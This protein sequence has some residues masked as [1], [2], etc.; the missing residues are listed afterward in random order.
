[1]NLLSEFCPDS[2]FGGKASGL[3]M[4]LRANDE[5]VMVP[6]GYALAW[7]EPFTGGFF[8]G[9]WAVR[10]SAVGE[11]SSS[12]SFAGQHDS[13]LNVPGDEIE[14][15]VAKVRES[16]NNPRV[17]AYRR[18]HGLE[19]EPR[20]GVVIQRMVPNVTAAAVAFTKDP[21]EDVDDIYIEYCEGLGDKLVGGKVTPKS[22]TWKREEMAMYSLGPDVWTK[23]LASIALRCERIIGGYADVEAAFNGD[24]WVCQARRVTT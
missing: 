15:A 22:V 5:H 20:M 10:S 4:L 7:N 12:T 19:G 3:S 16:V 6:R 2:E 23:R 14:S 17:L 9:M 1:M 8:P 13:L 11:D 24:W 18:K 21:Q